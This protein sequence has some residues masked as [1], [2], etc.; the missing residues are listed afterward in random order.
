MVNLNFIYPWVLLLLWLPPLLLGGG[1]WLA[2]LNRERQLRRFAGPDMRPRLMR[3]TDG[4]RRRL[5]LALAVTGLML[6]IM[7]CARPQWGEREI[8]IRARSRDLV[9]LL[10]VSRSM[11]AEDAQPNRLERA[12]AELY[13]LAASLDGNRIGLIAFRQG[14]VTLCPLTRD[15]GFFKF[16]LRGAWLDSAPAGPTDVASAI[17]AALDALSS[18]P[19]GH[20]AI[21]LVSDG[22]E[23]VGD[24]LAAAARAGDVAIFTLAIGSMEGAPVPDEAGGYLHFDGEKVVSRMELDLMQSIAGLTGAVCLPL[25]E[26]GRIRGLSLSDLY[27]RHMTSLT[28]REIVYAMT[29]RKVD[30]HNFFLLPAAVFLLAAALASRGRMP[31]VPRAGAHMALPL[32][33]PALLA[34]SLTAA[35]GAGVNR[36]AADGEGGRRFAPA[37][38]AL[39]AM[40]LLDQAGDFFREGEYEAAAAAFSA[41]A[42]GL[43][44]RRAGLSN[45]NAALSLAHAGELEQAAVLLARLRE[46]QQLA[47][48]VFLL[49]GQVRFAQASLCPPDDWSGKIDKLEQ[50]VQAFTGGLRLKPGKTLLENGLSAAVS[51][52]RRARQEEKKTGLMREYGGK[53]TAIILQEMLQRQREVTAMAAAAGFAEGPERI[54]KSEAAARLQQQNR[55]LLLPLEESV[56]GSP[57]LLFPEIE[58]S[59]LDRMMLQSAEDLQNL[60]SGTAGLSAGVEPLLFELWHPLAGPP[61]LFEMALAA[62]S[63]TFVCLPPPHDDDLAWQAESRQLTGFFSQR[64]AD[65]A[66]EWNRQAE[67]AEERITQADR[68]EIE[69]LAGQAIDRQDQAWRLME[70]ERDSLEPRKSAL[71]CLLRIREL[72]PGLP[73]D[74]PPE[75]EVQP[76]PGVNG[77]EPPE[78]DRFPEI[79]D[80]PE[81]DVSPRPPANNDL[82]DIERLLELARRREQEHADEQRR[83]ARRRPPRPEVRDW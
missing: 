66:G 20:G 31:R 25:G 11:L 5:Q 37:G 83:R 23:L 28:E 63:N 13:D 34:L 55:D 43:D 44:Y 12:K 9:V 73:P 57:D 47:P 81:P 76:D 26:A 68:Q 15:Y 35:Y 38:S 27:R 53:P 72:M 19:D 29:Q 39:A 58:M 24:A 18:E 71:Q 80:P 48:S 51:A 14:A 4:R 64:F 32:L 1:A 33:L 40:R 74:V 41:A 75:D 2:G 46:E 67:I 42:P 78:V 79:H 61:A 45:Y 17:D 16:A 54:G 56:H 36:L 77:E 21:L 10:D 60:E 62:Q 30:R 65:W 82:E 70:T 69:S 7:A 6:L 59:L 3:Q 22:E 52:L 50:S 8:E 49:L